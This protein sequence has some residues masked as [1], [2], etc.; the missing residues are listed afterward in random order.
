M[1]RNI[2]Y[3]T[4]LGMSPAIS[5]AIGS[6][7]G[8]HISAGHAAINSASSDISTS[9]TSKEEAQKDI[10]NDELTGDFNNTL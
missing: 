10:I 4:I 8:G 7:G 6:S 1:I 3:I 2:L 5:F 9:Y